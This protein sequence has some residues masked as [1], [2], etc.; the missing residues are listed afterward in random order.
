MR[1][2]LYKSSTQQVALAAAVFDEK[3]RIM[4]TPEGILPSR[5]ITNTYLERVCTTL[6]L[7][8]A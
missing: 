4:V 8:K 6:L 2:K 3:G 5:K 7:P 1:I